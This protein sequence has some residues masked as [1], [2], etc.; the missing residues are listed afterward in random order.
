MVDDS[1]KQ[2][3]TD[4]ELHEFFMSSQR[5]LSELEKSEA[6]VNTSIESLAGQVRRLAETTEIRMG[7]LSDKIDQSVER[8]RIT[9]PLIF[10]CI[11]TIVSVL[12][13]V[14]VIGRMA[15]TPVTEHLVQL[16][17]DSKSDRH[18]FL[19]HIQEQGHTGMQIRVK[20]LESTVDSLADKGEERFRFLDE[21][22]QREMRLLD[23][24]VEASIKGLDV[25]LQREMAD[26]DEK[27]KIISDTLKSRVLN[28]EQWQTEHDQRV[29]GI[30]A[31]QWERLKAL[32]RQVFG[33]PLS[34]G[35][36]EVLG[37]GSEF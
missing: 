29:V 13:V 19:D 20:A 35:F 18:E 4:D 23:D 15:I 21:S 14:G 10:A 1:G 5:R 26:G 32:E 37:S 7:Q 33:K 8:N 31:A 25:A 3:V 16:R 27:I 24:A 12:G 17:A 36:G 22:L 6:S 9:W 11:T 34:V 2:R 28:L 30:N